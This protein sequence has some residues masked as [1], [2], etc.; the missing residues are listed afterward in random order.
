MI[1]TPALNRR[2]FLKKATV[3][4]AAVSFPYAVP[5][6]ALGKAGSVAP[7]NRIVMGCIGT[8]KQGQFV[9]KNFLQLPQAQ[10]V[11]LCDCRKSQRDD[12]LAIIKERTGK[13]DCAL[14]NDFR[15]LCARTD[16]DAVLIASTDHWHVLHALEAARTG[17]DMYLEKP[18]GTSVEQAQVLRKAIKRYG[19]VFQFGTQQRSDRNFRFA[20]ELALN[21]YVGK[22]HTIKAAVPPSIK[23]GNFP[24][25]PVPAGLDYEMWLGPAPWAPYMKERVVTLGSDWE[26]LWWHISDYSLGWISAWGIHHIDIAQWG[27]GT[28]LTGPVE[29]E[30]T[31]VF[32]DEGLCDCATSW[33]VKM[34]YANG[35]TLDFTDN[36]QNPQGVRFEG[37]DGWVFVNRGGIDAHPKSLLTAEIGPDQIHL[38][39]SSHHQQ[40]FLDCVKS[41]GNPVSPIE[42]AVCSEIVCQLADIATRTKRKLTWNPEKEKFTDDEQANTMLKR[43]MRAPWHL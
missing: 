23:T 40:N 29:A 10:V 31:G 22:L 25:V 7:S 2:E 28:E 11:A 15:E 16:I 34:K 35:A 24:V 1:K 20:C 19:R 5:S 32:P 33:N 27:N 6:S 43:A 3:T 13:A 42:S 17:K 18:I 4:A 36:N 14:H 38:P 12:A 8:G 41:R 30:G 39:V 26:K 37:A 9:M 21:G